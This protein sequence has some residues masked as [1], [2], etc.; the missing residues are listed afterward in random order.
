MYKSGFVCPE[1]A[2]IQQTN[3]ESKLYQQKKSRPGK[4]TGPFE[5]KAYEQEQSV[6][7]LASQV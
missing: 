3:S 1:K 4:G 5:A 2:L 6:P 7:R